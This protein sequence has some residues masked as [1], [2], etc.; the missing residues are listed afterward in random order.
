MLIATLNFNDSEGE[1][2]DSTPSKKNAQQKSASQ[3]KQA[4]K[5]DEEDLTSKIYNFRS[6]MISIILPN[7]IAFSTG[8]AI[9]KNKA[10]QEIISLAGV[11]TNAARLASVEIVGHTDS[12]KPSAKAKYIDNWSLSAARAGAIAKIL[13]EQG[14]SS[15]IVHA[16]GV[17]D[18]KPLYPHYDKLGRII[19]KN[20]AENRRVEIILKRKDL[21]K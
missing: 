16:A 14:V 2:F 13:V 1:E 7:S 21:K 11:F 19:K 3:D 6:P 8:S 17:A 15:Q 12:I 5:E 18:S 4:D 10:R 9:L 20:L